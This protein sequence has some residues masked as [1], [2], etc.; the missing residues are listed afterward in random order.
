M[1]N[2]TRDP[3]FLQHQKISDTLTLDHYGKSKMFSKWTYEDAHYKKKSISSWIIELKYGTRCGGEIVA[4]QKAKQEDIRS[5]MSLPHVFGVSEDEK[6]AL[7]FV[8]SYMDYENA[9]GAYNNL[10]NVGD[11]MSLWSE[12]Q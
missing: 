9:V 3:R 1:E 2:D 8:A 6:Y 12:T 5:A 11:I 10:R 7:R 4:W